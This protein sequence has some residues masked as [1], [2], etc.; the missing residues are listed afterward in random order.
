MSKRIADEEGRGRR[1]RP[2]IDDQSLPPPDQS[3]PRRC[4]TALAVNV[5]PLA[6]M[7]KF[8]PCERPRA[9]RRIGGVQVEP[10]GVHVERGEHRAVG[11]HVEAR[12][13][14]SKW[15]NTAPTASQIE[16]GRIDVKRLAHEE[17]L[18][19]RCVLSVDVEALRLEVEADRVAVEQ[20]LPREVRS[21]ASMSKFVPVN[22]P[23]RT[24]HRWRPGRNRR[25]PRR[26]GRTP[27]HTV[28]VEVERINVEGLAHEEH[29][30]EVRVRRVDVEALASASKPIASLSN[31][32]DVKF[33]PVASMSKFVPLKDAAQTCVR[34]VQVEA[35][36]VHVE[37][38]EHRPH[39]IDVK[40]LPWKLSCL[41][42]SR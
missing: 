18:A 38:G 25:R 10:V 8:V 26:T 40:V 4:R 20:H 11:V 22:D 34:G 3:P 19:E 21:V 6:S 2:G 28:Q 23:C 12:P 37:R 14:T 29:R 39:S 33:A 41:L 13:S 5:A 7:S 35:L 30:A 36:G 15:A 32:T 9:E 42:P 24:S 27:R 16:V 31:S 1:W 17:H